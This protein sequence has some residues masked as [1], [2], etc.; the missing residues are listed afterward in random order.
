M[1]HK[2][3]I[4]S[5][6]GVLLSA[7]SFAVTIGE[8]ENKADSNK[9]EYSFERIDRMDL[10]E[11]HDCMTGAYERIR[12]E[13]LIKAHKKEIR[14]IEWSI[15]LKSMGASEEMRHYEYGRL[16]SQNDQ[17][18]QL[19]R[20]IVQAQDKLKAPISPCAEF[21]EIARNMTKE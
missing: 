8:G 7:S 10:N 1:R 18:P 14:D 6:L 19:R 2:V 5:I 16:L 9:L 21:F 4:G 13:A 3:A 20:S 11:L 17:I 12:L 15:K